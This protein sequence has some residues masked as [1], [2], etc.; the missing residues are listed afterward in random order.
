LTRAS[1]GKVLPVRPLLEDHVIQD[2]G[3]IPTL[4]RCLDQLAPEPLDDKM[5]TFAHA[6]HSAE[7][8]GGAWTDYLPLHQFLD[9]PRDYLPDGRYR[10]ILH[11]GWGVALAVEAFGETVARQ[12]DNLA[13][14][15]RA[16]V[17]AHIRA[18]YSGVPTLESCLEGLNVQRWMCFRAMPAYVADSPA[19]HQT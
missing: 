18:E 5:T 7:T 14:P 4:A 1:D 9:W 13:I 6:S 11:N 17:E 12:S 10:R 8:Y 19:R 15:V 2:F 3:K 16:V